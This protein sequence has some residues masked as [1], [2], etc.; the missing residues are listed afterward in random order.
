MYVSLVLKV[1]FTL[2][3]LDTQCGHMGLLQPYIFMLM[4]LGKNLISPVHSY[5]TVTNN[6]RTGAL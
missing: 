1:I 4:E 6:G 5:I 3:L 2:C